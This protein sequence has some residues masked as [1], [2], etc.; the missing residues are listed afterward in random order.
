MGY[1]PGRWSM[2]NTTTARE[3]IKERT[4]IQMIPEALLTISMETDDLTLDDV[5]L[6]DTED[7]FSVFKFRKFLLRYGSWSKEQVGKIKIKELEQVAVLLS[8]AM[9]NTAVPPPNGKSSAPGPQEYMPQLPSR[10]G[11]EF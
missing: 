3:R 8:E 10:S 2:V 9:K 5:A 7:G 4:T 11:S 1:G 6:F